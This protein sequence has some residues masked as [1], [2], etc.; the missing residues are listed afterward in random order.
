MGLSK[1]KYLLLLLS[2]PLASHL[3]PRAQKP[4]IWRA[5]HVVFGCALGAELPYGQWHR[6]QL[7]VPQSG[8]AVMPRTQPSLLLSIGSLRASAERITPVGK[9][10]EI[11]QANLREMA[12]SSQATRR[13]SQVLTRLFHTDE[14]GET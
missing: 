6:E 4:H 3:Y 9:I 7:P 10:S 2:P 5:K 14:G 13:S 11:I 12:D 8:V 1:R